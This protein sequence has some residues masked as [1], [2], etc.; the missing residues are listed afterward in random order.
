VLGTLD[1]VREIAVAHRVTAIAVAGDHGL[2]RDFLRSLAWSLEGTEIELMVAPTV[3]VCVGPRIHIRP[4]A[5]L[6][7]LHIEKP[8]LRGGRRLLKI[9]VDRVLAALILLALLPLLLSVAVL[10]RATSAGPALFRQRRVGRDGRLFTLLKFRTMYVDA[11]ARREQL[12]ELDVHH[13][14]GPLFKVRHDPRVTRVGRFLRRYSIDELPQ[15]VNVLRGDMSLV[16]PR[17]PLPAE[18]ETYVGPTGRRMLVSPG[19]TGLWQISG[20]A[21]LE[22]HES[23]RLDLYYVENWSLAL[24]ALILWKTVPAVLR[25]RGAY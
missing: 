5:G 14:D 3:M 7:L 11:E 1:R 13:G 16:G 20:R 21:D 18:V 6:P 19:L 24:D 4:V 23:V 22:W 9:V 2:D 15:L 10:V 12:A 8:E 25:H 17:P